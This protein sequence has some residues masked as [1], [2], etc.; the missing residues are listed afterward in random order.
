MIKMWNKTW[1][2]WK[3]HYHK[4]SKSGISM[5]SISITN[6]N[7]YRF[8]GLF[9]NMN[10]PK[11]AQINSYDGYRGI[12]SHAD[13]MNWFGRDAVY[14]LR[15]QGSASLHFGLHQGRKPYEILKDLF[16][17][18]DEGDILKMSGIFQ[19]VFKHGIPSSSKMMTQKA[20]TWI[21]RDVMMNSVGKW[22]KLD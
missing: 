22:T 15:V 21:F 12:D 19:T 20:M 13:E 17:T 8:R 1:K 16:V 7:K 4:L 3:P 2:G 10:E 11:M 18:V 5:E 6:F 9:K 14:T